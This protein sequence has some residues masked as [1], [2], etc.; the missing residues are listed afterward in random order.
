MDAR[1]VTILLRLIHL[2]A[3]IFWAGTAFMVAG[4]LV[5]A[6]RARGREGGLFLQE[7]MLKRRLS[8]SLGLAMLLTVVSG[9]AMYIRLSVASHG[10]WP[11]TPPG[12]AYGVGAVAAI[13]AGAIGAY[14]GGGGS[15][16]MASVGPGGRSP[17]QQAEMG[18]LQARI[19]AGTRIA[20]ALLAVAASAMAVGRYL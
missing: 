2:L 1:T 7:L 19:S 6:A 16:R 5:P 10:T 18:R 3:G 14:V 15:R 11:A 8:S 20:A 12:M 13:A 9:L 4:Y 17:E